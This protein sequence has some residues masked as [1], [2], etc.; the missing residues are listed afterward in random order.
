MKIRLVTLICL[1]TFVALLSGSLVPA[2]VSASSSA[3]VIG[4][5][6]LQGRSDYGGTDVFFDGNQVSLTS[7][8]GQ[9]AM[10]VANGG[11]HVIR[12]KHKGYISR[13]Y[14]LRDPVGLITIPDTLLRLGDADGDDDVDIVD[15]L[16]VTTSYGTKPPND[17]R[18]DLNGDG[19]VGVID[20]IGLMASYNLVGPLGWIDPAPAA[21]GLR[22]TTRTAMPTPRYNLGVAVVDGKLYAI[23]GLT[24]QPVGVVEVYDPVSNTWSTRAPMPTPRS[25]L[26]V[27]VVDGK[28]YAL[29]GNGDTGQRLG[30][31]EEY[32]PATDTWQE[33]TSLPTRRA[34]LGAAVVNG[35]IYA[36][37]GAAGG[38]LGTV[39]EY[40]P[41]SNTW[42]QRMPMPT[43]REG[44]AVTAA[45]GK[46]WAIGGYHN[47]ALDVV[48]V[49]NPTTNTWTA[50]TP[51]P[52]ARF[53]LGAAPLGEGKLMVV[54]GW[55]TT[56]LGIAEEYNVAADTW[57]ARTAM[58]TARANLGVA[59]IG[60]RLYAVGGWYGRTLSTLEEATPSTIPS[61]GSPDVPSNF[62]W[63]LLPKEL[64]TK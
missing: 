59:T 35:K 8:N 31:V 14:V 49:Y 48:E 39:E 56:G 53:A 50:K 25:D 37:G 58:P 28:I 38:Y 46:V 24:D 36:V 43:S 52:T 63:H 21:G 51:M 30:T 11:S 27:A 55:G 15:V 18:A 40:D 60:D 6:T 12:V 64:Q 61:K 45:D 2:S 26:A 54:G 16:I 17:P 47:A 5:V 33:R 19:E 23:G 22:W 10:A 20:L 3:V 29:G 32:D 4:R 57:A 7:A 1:L 13:E 42:T 41:S 62:P 9:F 34:G 44:L